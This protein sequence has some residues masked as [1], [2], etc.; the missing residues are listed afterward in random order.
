ML[1]IYIDGKKYEVAEGSTILDACR[2]AGIE[3]PVMCYL[4]GC[5]HFTSC[6]VCVVKDVKSKRLIPSC[7]AP[8]VD[9]MEIEACTEEV[10]EG[11]RVAL[12]LLLSEHLGDCEAPC[13][14][15]CPAHMNIPQMLHQ[16]AAGESVKALATVKRNI[17]L[18]AVIG[19]I[20][21]APCEKGC[22]RGRQDSPV[23][24]RMSE[25]Y[26][27][28][29]DMDAGDPRLPECAQASGKQVAVVGAGP[30]GLSA[31]FYLQQMGHACTV[32][33]DRGMPGG[34][35]IDGV[36]EHLLPRDITAAEINIIR[37]TGVVFK[38][39]QTLGK[40]ITLD[41][42]AGEYDAVVLALGFKELDELQ[43]LGL[44]L[45]K[46][47]IKV[48]KHSLTTNRRG[49]FAG[50]G[51]IGNGKTMAI[52]SLADGKAIAHSVDTFLSGHNPQGVQQLFNSA[53]GA[54]KKE[55]L[56]EFMR[57]AA[58]SARHEP[59]DADCGFAKQEAVA[60]AER[61]LHCDCRKL[62]S[63]RL[64]SY[65]DEYDAHQNRYKGQERKPLRIIM[66]H[67]RVVYEPG[68]CIK[69]GIC[70]R[71]TGQ[72]DEP[73][74]MAFLKRGYDSEIGVPFNDSL[75][76]GLTHSSEQCVKECPT[77]A[78]AFVEGEEV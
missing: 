38:Q 5:T 42:L 31:A 71:I 12:E 14:R 33:D 65:S 43:P 7:S 2:Q 40:D 35:L 58:D 22:R 27:A 8:V 23:S 17:A 48:D 13:H 28:D 68:K 20:C 26:V 78:L 63:C 10:R 44:D 52:R 15:I 60:E 45:S 61:C 1:K 54:V 29:L 34:Q 47:G 53:I 21:P 49:V 19:R 72:T 16:I 74:G 9:D 59:A 67:P 50:G 73:L 46:N 32:F 24:I 51:V 76:Q 56:V 62:K 39:R 18:P 57:G 25:R 75:E 77:G 6:M 41:S 11:R 64:R 30:T 70:V 37:R 66:Q 3:I 69:C 55:E 4:D 36:P